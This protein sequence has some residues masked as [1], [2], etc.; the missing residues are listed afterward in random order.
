MEKVTGGGNTLMQSGVGI[1]ASGGA[2]SYRLDDSRQAQVTQGTQLQEALHQQDMRSFSDAKHNTFTKAADY[3]AHLA[4]REN[5]GKTFNYESMGENGK[6]LQNAVSHMKNLSKQS[7]LTNRQAAEA[8]LEMSITAGTPFAGITGSNASITGKGSINASI[9]SDKSESIQDAI[10]QDKQVSENYNNLLKAASN[11][12]WTKENSIDKS[13]S[14][15]LRGSYEEQ[16]RLERQA[17]ISQQRVE[18][19]H[20]VQSVVNSQSAGSSK[21][22]YQ[23]VVDGIKQEY[24]VDAKTAH[25]MA[26]KRSPEAQRVWQNIQR[27]DHYVDDLANNISHNRQQVSGANAANSLDQF[28]NEHSVKITQ[29]SEEKVKQHAKDKGQDIDELTG[30]AQ[31]AIQISS[32]T[33]QN[34][35]KTMI[36]ENEKSREETRNNIEDEGK[37]RNEDINKSQKNE[38][39]DEPAITSRKALNDVMKKRQSQE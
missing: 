35:H 23:E 20:R 22:M 28:P 31:K 12:S 7:N 21:D 29:N 27:E 3:V 32:D 30:A 5:A 10:N 4:E 16:Q 36:K 13:Y 15:S 26:D 14:D 1:T 18:D 6:I 38:V 9:S 19:W 11:E 2:T 17:S 34:K 25:D 24:R 39:G 8:G 33:T 37:K